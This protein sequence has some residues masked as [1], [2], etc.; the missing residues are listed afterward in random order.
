MVS[1]VVRSFVTLCCLCLVPGPAAQA[2]ERE[3]VHSPEILS[4]FPAGISRGT[5]VEIEIRGRGLDTVDTLWFAAQR[6]KSRISKV[7]EIDLGEIRED[8]TSTKKSRR[9]HRVLV[10]VEADASA[11]VGRDSLR[12]VTRRGVSNALPF[13]VH[14]ERVV[15]ET[16]NNT[17][18]TAQPLT[19]P[20]VVSG[21]IDEKGK[22]DYYTF[23]A[24]KGEELVFAALARTGPKQD[25]DVG[26][27]FDAQLCLYDPNG[28]WFDPRRLNRLAISYWPEWKTHTTRLT[29]RF[30]NN[31]RYLLEIGSFL[32]VSGPD[33]FYQLRIAPSAESNPAGAEPC[34]ARFAPAEWEERAFDRKLDSDCLRLLRSRTVSKQRLQN[35]VGKVMEEEPN[36]TASEALEL[37]L[38]ALVEGIIEQPGDVD[39][40]RFKVARGQR[41]AFE[42][43]APEAAPPDFNPRLGISDADDGNAQEL[44][45][46]I[47]RKV[48]GDGDDWIKSIEPKTIYTFERDANCLL[49][50]RDMTSRY[51][52]PRFRY[53]IVIRRQIPHVGKIEVKEDHVNLIAGGAGKLTVV[54]EQEEG[55]TG[56]IALTLQNLPSGVQALP[57][58]DVE[59]DEPPPLD[60]GP[61]ERFVA[62]SQT[63]TIVLAGSREAPITR[64]PQV[65]RLSARPVV[66]G[67]LGTPLYV[68]EIPLMVIEPPVVAESDKV[69]V[70][71]GSDARGTKENDRD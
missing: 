66:E 13:L 31:G 20:G 58:T 24:G 45:N 16:L 60:K 28:S 63:A 38:P 5:A 29:H 52:N 15:T 18:Q 8:K 21:K 47:Y 65:V 61:K 40:F 7:E 19:I 2:E 10:E 56:E 41:L 37:E 6:H 68:Q 54:T 39:Y 59:P 27:G 53:R 62:K 3:R 4:V 67:R 50:V 17:P 49:Q 22:F 33:C 48:A 69:P 71:E 9:G 32:G 12:L 51:G 25:F 11:R 42:V 34:F 36:G 64:M 23:E 57:G 43:E 44:F 14:S 70:A 35:V 30:E 46:N 26:H 55:F 1:S